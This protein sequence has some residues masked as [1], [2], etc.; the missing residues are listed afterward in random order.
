MSAEERQARMLDAFVRWVAR[1]H[2]ESSLFESPGV[3]AAVVPSV[4]DHSIPNSVVYGSRAELEAAHPLLAA[5]YR[6]AGIHAWTVWVPDSDEDAE[7]FLA[8]HGHAFDG[9][10]AAMTLDLGGFEPSDQGDLDWDAEATPAELAELND[11]AYGFTAPAG[12]G[13]AVTHAEAAEGVRLYRARVNGETASVLGAI[14]VGTDAGIFFV[15]TPPEMRG[16]GLSGR[17]LAKAL[18]EARERGMK[19]S[20]LQASA[21][22]FPVYERLGYEVLYR[23]RLLE[24]RVPAEE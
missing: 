5:R 20:S 11:L 2:P 22:G 12:M 15:A 17:L 21:M 8:A 16:R 13:P 4:P 10:P 7:A 1:A 14:D 19:T 24:C 18:V 9:E 23:Y 3:T 6:D